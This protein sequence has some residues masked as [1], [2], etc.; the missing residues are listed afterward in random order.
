MFVKRADGSLVK[1]TEK[2][3]DF[4]AI[5]QGLITEHPDLLVGDQIDPEQPR[6]WLVI[7]QEVGVP[8]AEGGG[9]Y[10][11]LDVLLLDQDGVPTLIEVKRSTDTRIR[12]EVVGQMLDYAAHT[13]AFIP[14]ERMRSLLEDRCSK[15]DLD[16]GLEVVALTGTDDP[17]EFWSNV[18]ANIEAGRVRLLFVADRL[19]VELRRVIEFWNQHTDPVEVLGLE[20]RQ[21]VGEDLVTF[22]P[23]VYG[24]TI[25]ATEKKT[26][27]GPARQWDEGSFFDAL[28]E[29][30]TEAVTVGRRIFD[31]A[32]SR[33][34]DIQWGRGAV[35]GTM[36]PVL[37]HGGAD[38]ATMSVTTSARLEVRFSDMSKRQPFARP[39]HRLDLLARLNQAGASIPEDGIDR[40]PGVPFAAIAESMEEFLDAW[41]WY[42]GQVVEHRP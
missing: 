25:R 1:M 38:H 10:W 28:A 11:S 23:Q 42:L 40:W 29:H 41:D 37:D 13:V 33:G 39:E 9:G 22:V 7:D 26:R 14:A 31:W 21:F 35:Y 15:A 36:L 8:A 12:R 20:V 34:L 32:I 16:P 27:R 19:P 30:G 4:E 3:Y 24:Q 2:G 6:R 5:L 17:E 18:A